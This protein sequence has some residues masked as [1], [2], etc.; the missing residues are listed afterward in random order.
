MTVS[1]HD[2]FSDEYSRPVDHS[3]LSI[4]GY[5]DR[6]SYLPGES[7]SVHASSTH[8]TGSLRLVRLGHD[9]QGFTKAPVAEPTPISLA[10]RDVK[11]ESQG[12]V[13]TVHLPSAP[14]AVRT[15]AWVS[16]LP[17]V[18][19]E[20]T[21]LTVEGLRLAINAAGKV[22][23]TVGGNKVE[24]QTSL[25]LRRWYYLIAALDATGRPFLIV[26]PQRL[27]IAESTPD[28]VASPPSIS[29]SK[30]SGTLTIGRGFNGKLEAVS[31]GPSE[32]EA[33]QDSLQWI[34]H[35]SHNGDQNA[36]SRLTANVP[37]SFIE[38]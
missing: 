16:L 5:T 15:W 26:R 28:R 18:T 22:V 21:L 8:R 31:I 10:H 2:A 1:D 20:A 25:Q 13:Y 37:R 11:L 24:S 38:R 35:I 6:L 3:L 23:F 30:R 36:A 29:W 34:L 9:G 4:T 32:D 12:L 7:V 14:L 17:K 33:E 27:G 19:R